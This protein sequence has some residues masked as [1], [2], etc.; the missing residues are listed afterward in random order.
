MKYFFLKRFVLNLLGIYSY[1]YVTFLTRSS[2]ES[3]T[4]VRDGVVGVNWIN[5]WRI[6]YWLYK[7]SDIIVVNES[8]KKMHPD[9][10]ITIT[11]IKEI[12]ARAEEYLRQ[13]IKSNGSVTW[14]GSKSGLVT[15][16]KKSPEHAMLH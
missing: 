15:R 7:K 5:C 8:L 16:T 1:Y 6:G 10:K 11:Y 2:D 12:S 9:V 14:N 3:P 13:E 4:Y